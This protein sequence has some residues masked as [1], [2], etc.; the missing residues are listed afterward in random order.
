MALG[1]VVEEREPAYVSTG[2][3][4]DADTVQALVTEARRRF[5]SH[6]DGENSQL[7]PALARFSRFAGRR[8]PL[9]EDLYASASQTN[10]RNRSTA[11]LL[12]SYGHIYCDAKEATDLCVRQCSL[13]VSA[14]TRRDGATLADG[15]VNPVM[16]QRVIDASAPMRRERGREFEKGQGPS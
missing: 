12:E 11:R 6:R 7:H 15:D 13:N 14:R 1:S 4:P 16:K 8:L 10:S 2:H 3:L 5:H 9:N